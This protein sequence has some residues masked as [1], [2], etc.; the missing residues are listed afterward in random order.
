[1]KSG[2]F[3][4]RVPSAWVGRVDSGRVRCLLADWFRHPKPLPEDPGPGDAFL[5]VSVARRP[6]RAFAAAIGE[7][8]SAALRRLI[9]GYSGLPAAKPVVGLG[10]CAVEGKPVPRV[11]VLTRPMLVAAEA[12]IECAE[13]AQQEAVA[14]YERQRQAL[15]ERWWGA[16]PSAQGA[17][18]TSSWAGHEEQG[19]L[20]AW[21]QRWGL[22][23][24]GLGLAAGV[25]FGRAGL[26]VVGL[27]VVG[28]LVGGSGGAV[29]SAAAGAL[30]ALLRKSGA[31]PQ[32]AVLKAQAIPVSEGFVVWLPRR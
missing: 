29:L 23:I 18:H 30:I 12:P 31:N 9:A 5:R 1:M 10:S 11:E 3:T 13:K 21:W 16:W 4:V 20:A 6:V 17:V 26:L 22:L 24:I 8:P 28:G 27:G 15:Q 14:E 19:G 25:M 2:A 7:E 32:A